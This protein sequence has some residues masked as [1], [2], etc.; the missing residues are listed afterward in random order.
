[1]PADITITTD[2]VETDPSTLDAIDKILFNNIDKP[3]SDEIKGNMVVLRAAALHYISVV[4]N[5]NKKVYLK[6]YLQ[7]FQKIIYKHIQKQKKI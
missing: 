3:V 6:D 2:T 7:K 1:M 4:E 5:L